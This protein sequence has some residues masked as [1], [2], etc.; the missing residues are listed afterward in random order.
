MFAQATISLI[1][2]NVSYR[3]LELG[4]APFWIGLISATFAIAPIL[5][6][7]WIGRFTDRGNDAISVWIGSSITLLACTCFIFLPAT[8]MSLIAANAIFGLGQMFFL[9][10]G[11][12]VCE[13]S[14]AGRDARDLAFG[15]YMVANALGTALGPMVLGLLPGS[16]SIPDTQLLFLICLAGAIATLGAALW[17]RPSLKTASAKRQEVVIPVTELLNSPGMLLFIFCSIMTITSQELLAIYMPVLG[18]ERQIEASHI[19]VALAIRAIATMVA[20]SLYSQAVRLVGR[21]PLMFASILGGA[22]GMFLLSV[23]LSI[24]FLYAACA[25]IGFCLGF[26]AIASMTGVVSVA[27]EGVKATATS[28]RIMGNRGGQI[29]LPVVG[30]LVATALGAGSV[31]FVTATGLCGVA[32]GLVRKWHSIPRA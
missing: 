26:A 21:V 32:L 2:V 8:A 1:K 18:L 30:G 9:T 28:L 23:P 19:G 13:R 11:Q 25:V 10:G 27:P 6:G 16:S 15:N 12:I 5:C 20:R 7:L 3:A 22:A 24:T 31:F 4:L 14:A 17:M 29:C